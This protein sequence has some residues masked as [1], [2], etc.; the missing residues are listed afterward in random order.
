MFG[1]TFIITLVA[2]FVF[3]LA[4]GGLY[5]HYAK[6]REVRGTQDARKNITP[7]TTNYNINSMPDK[8]IENATPAEA[9]E[10]IRK[11]KSGDS[12]TSLS[13]DDFYA[14]KEKVNN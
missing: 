10:I 14:L 2:V 4:I 12:P 8:T 13:R 1:S 11:E 7:N 9:R 3:V 6:R 5:R